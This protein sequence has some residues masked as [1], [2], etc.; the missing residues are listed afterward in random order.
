MLR[1]IGC[2]AANQSKSVVSIFASY[3]CAPRVIFHMNLYSGSQPSA[4]V[5]VLSADHEA[6]RGHLS[7]S[8]GQG[9][10]ASGNSI[11]S[12]GSSAPCKSAEASV[13]ADQKQ[14][15]PSDFFQFPSGV[16][17][18]L[19]LKVLGPMVDQSELPFRVLCRRYGVQLCYTPMYKRFAQA[20][21]FASAGFINVDLRDGVLPQ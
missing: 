5:S 21:A 3:L 2:D 19:P 10:A 17:L 11:C 4:R 13:C 18:R 9:D 20:I 12:H 8:G 7:S 15:L 16:K 14:A 6:D 1:T